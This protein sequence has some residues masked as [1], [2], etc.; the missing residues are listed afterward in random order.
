MTIIAIRPM[1]HALLASSPFLQA[2]QQI[3]GSSSRAFSGVLHNISTSFTD[4]FS[5]EATLSHIHQQLTEPLA[6]VAQAETSPHEKTI[7]SCAIVGGF[8]GLMIGQ[9]IDLKMFPDEVHTTV[10]MSGRAIALGLGGAALG[11]AIGGVVGWL[12]L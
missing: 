7:G 9:M 10:E 1:S 11:S 12:A 4:H 8:V 3:T 6:Q 2:G 5:M